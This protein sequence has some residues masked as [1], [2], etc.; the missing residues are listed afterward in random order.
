MAMSN[1][2]VIHWAYVKD[3]SWRLVVA[4][5]QRGLCYVGSQDKDV[6]ELADWAQRRFKNF[7]L[8]QNEDNVMPYL[9]Q[10]KEYLRRQR[11]SFTVPMDLQ[12]TPFQLEVWTVM[13]DIPYGQTVSYQEL[14][15]RIRKPNAV[16]AVGSAIGK[17]PVL[18]IAPC[19]RII[20]KSGRLTGYRGGLRMKEALLLLE[21]G[22]SGV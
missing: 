5:T 9:Q 22:D 11:V 6:S 16:R 19:H 18:I 1:E 15:E 14:A 20:G 8:V 3:G 13:N 4:A 7:R 21:R 10:L 17:N 2:Q 12:G